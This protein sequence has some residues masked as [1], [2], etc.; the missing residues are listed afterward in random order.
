MA[1]RLLVTCHHFLPTVSIRAVVVFSSATD[2]VGAR[3]RRQQGGESRVTTSP[4][5]SDT[6]SIPTSRL[7]VGYLFANQ[8]TGDVGNVK[9]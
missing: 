1:V 9:L 6:S 5:T 4:S 8:P 7:P 2:C 3:L